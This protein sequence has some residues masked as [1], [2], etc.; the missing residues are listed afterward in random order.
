MGVN[1]KQ[2][3]ASFLALQRKQARKQ[4]ERK[5]IKHSKKRNRNNSNDKD[6]EDCLY[7]YDDLID[8]VTQMLFFS[9]E[10]LTQPLKW[11]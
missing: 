8:L 6:D 11:R 4:L 5:R 3:K 1:K 7:Q 2:V 9:L 10:T